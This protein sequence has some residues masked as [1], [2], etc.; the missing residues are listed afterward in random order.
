[1]KLLLH[2]CCGPCAATVA[3]LFRDQ[4]HQV[5]GWFFNP[6]IH[7]AQ[8]HQRRATALAE[9]AGKAGFALLPPGPDVGL[10]EFLLAI[11]RQGG[12]RCPACYRVRLAAAA[13]QAAAL[14][15]EAFSTTLLLSPYQD[16][17]TIRQVGQEAGDRYGVTFHLA[18]LR[19]HY[20]ESCALA[21]S[22]E[23]YRQN[24]CGCIFSSLE[25]AERRM[26]RSLRKSAMAVA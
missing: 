11:A 14:G 4:G 15:F 2:C 19:E 1:M 6:N 13:Q 8:E 21:H 24:Y 16:S 25:R 20:Q 18:D 7:P 10:A 26:L 9:A 3:Q 12:Q 23:L 22:L 17:E 5:A